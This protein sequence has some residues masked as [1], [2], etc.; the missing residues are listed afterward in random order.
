MFSSDQVQLALIMREYEGKS[1]E[2]IAN[3]MNTSIHHIQEMIATDQYIALLKSG[4]SPSYL[5]SKHTCPKAAT[6]H[7]VHHKHIKL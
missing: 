4:W 2:E 6:S 7:T 5:N 1:L 3:V